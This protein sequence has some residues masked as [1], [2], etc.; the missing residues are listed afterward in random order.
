MK[1]KLFSA[2]L[3]SQMTTYSAS[4]LYAL[5]LKQEESVTNVQNPTY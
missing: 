4:E 5:R 3:S 1:M 2:Q